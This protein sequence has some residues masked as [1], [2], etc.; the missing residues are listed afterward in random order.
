M[1]EE[2]NGGSDEHLDEHLLDSDAG[3]GVH[4]NIDAVAEAS[5]AVVAG[6][7]EAGTIT[8][9]SKP[10]TWQH[11]GQETSMRR[12]TWVCLFLWLGN[13][14]FGL[15][16]FAVTADLPAIADSYNITVSDAAVSTELFMLAAA[17][18]SIFFATVA[19]GWSKK[20]VLVAALIALIVSA[21]FAIW[22]PLFEVLVTARV[23]GAIAQAPYTAVATALLAAMAPP[24]QMGLRWGCLPVDPN[25]AI[26][27]YLS[28]W[29]VSQVLAVPVATYLGDLSAEVGSWHNI[30]WPGLALALISAVGAFIVLPEGIK[31]VQAKIKEE[32]V[33]FKKPLF[34]LLIV[35]MTFAYCG[36]IGSHTYFTGMMFKV[37]YHTSDL[38]WLNGVFGLGVFLG[39]TFFGPVLMKQKEKTVPPVLLALIGVLAAFYF[40]VQLADPE[41]V[42]FRVLGALELFLNGF[43]GFSL[44]PPFFALAM[45]VGSEGATLASASVMTAFGL[46][47]GFAIWLGGV[48]VS[49]GEQVNATWVNETT[50]SAK[51]ELSPWGVAAPKWMSAALSL[52][53]SIF[54]FL[55]L[56][57]KHSRG[58]V[59]STAASLT[60][61]GTFKRVSGSRPVT[62]LQPDVE[63]GGISPGS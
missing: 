42:L 53:G 7:S 1:P 24:A 5:P 16:E 12:F 31:T 9:T 29:T 57:I 46:G 26:V 11:A 22:S 49:L 52:F 19:V 37:G 30:F 33:I 32:A 13:V 40:V 27:Y 8:G 39:N 23:L 25:H 38:W 45:E 43:L 48:G 56:C 2:K 6:A 55:A 28:G 44:V 18:S 34:W 50:V 51:P 47:I 15:L 4:V 60:D 59:R 20:G 35:G 10:L 62:A 17:I 14:A 61:A 21:A 41:N 3:K 36:M 63:V 54:V 58:K